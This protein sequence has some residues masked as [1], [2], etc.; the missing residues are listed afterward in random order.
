[1]GSA[2]EMWGLLSHSLPQVDSTIF[3]NG[4]FG[5][6]WHHI[7]S[8]LNNNSRAIKFGVHEELPIEKLNTNFQHLI[9]VCQNETSNGT[10]V[11]N[12]LLRNLRESNP[13]ALIAVDATSSMSGIYLDFKQADIWFASVQK[14]FG[15]PAGLC[16]VLLSPRVREYLPLVSKLHYNNLD[17]LYTKAAIQ[18]TIH[19]PN[20]LNIYLLHRLMQSIDSIEKIHAETVAK[21]HQW[22]SFLQE[23]H[24]KLLPQNSAVISDTVFTINYPEE[25]L[26]H[27]LES[28]YKQGFMLGKG[29]GEFAKNTF[30][31]ANFPAIHKNQIAALQ[32]VLA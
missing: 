11:S 1:V 31:I 8:Q 10:Q 32:Q 13:N 29:Y 27:F 26:K 18:Q 6:K 30:R 7:H 24:L 21:A 5:H 16:V 19:T 23:T 17:E 20:T 25:K 3:Y 2:T 14:C 28:I 9:G 4:S 12:Q 22:R 15:L